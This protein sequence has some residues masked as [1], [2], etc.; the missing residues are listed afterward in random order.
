MSKIFDVTEEKM[1]ETSSTF[2]LTE[3]DVYK[4]QV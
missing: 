3:I 1:K 4:R 2:T